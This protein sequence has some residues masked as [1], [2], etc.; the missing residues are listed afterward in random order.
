M[1][2]L[3][4]TKDNY[5]RV[6]ALNHWLEIAMIEKGPLFY[7]VNK[8]NTI[9]KY[10]MNYKNQKIL[11]NAGFTVPIINGGSCRYKPLDVSQIGSSQYSE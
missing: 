5:C 9:E 7:K 11:E 6:K 8:S 4:R 10:T 3:P 2:F 1:I